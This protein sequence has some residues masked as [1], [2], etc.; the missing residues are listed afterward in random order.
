MKNLISEWYDTLRESWG[1]EKL[2]E[3][4][5]IKVFCGI[6]SSYL[7]TDFLV[8]GL[9]KEW[10][11]AHP[12]IEWMPKSK[13]LPYY[14]EHGALVVQAHPFREGGSIDHIRLFPRCVHGVEIAN[15]C[16]SDFENESAK[17]YA[18]QYGLLEFAGSDNHGYTTSYLGGMQSETPIETITD[19]VK[20]V[21]EGEMQVFTK[22]L[23][24]PFQN[25]RL[26]ELEQFQNL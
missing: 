8:Y 11:L 4:I 20:K 3:E 1:L 25:A 24:P 16:R 2:S 17:Q 18:A 19:F 23:E 22:P 14:M 7:G 10:F 12:E 26:Y 9:D 15:A 13:V 21:K 5:G 6:E